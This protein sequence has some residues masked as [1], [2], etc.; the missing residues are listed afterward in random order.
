MKTF[1]FIGLKQ[2][3]FEM[4]KF[5]LTLKSHV[6]QFKAAQFASECEMS[7]SFSMFERRPVSLFLPIRKVQQNSSL[8]KSTSVKHLHLLTDRKSS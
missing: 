7:Y 5:M 3:Q 1:T 8:V 2:R 6:V 4:K